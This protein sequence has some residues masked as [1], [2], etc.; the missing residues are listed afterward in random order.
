M[1]VTW[2]VLAE[3]LRSVALIV[4]KESGE[5]LHLRAHS[6][7]ESNMVQVQG[8]V[9]CDFQVSTAVFNVQSLA[10]IVVD[11]VIHNIY[12]ELPADFTG[13]GCLSGLDTSFC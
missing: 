6:Y 5:Q 12:R 1:S 10:K 2:T 11:C 9:Q 13:K 4:K 7:P 8:D 3:G